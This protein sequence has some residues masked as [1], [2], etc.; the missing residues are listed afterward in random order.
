V[1]DVSQ[2]VTWIS[3]PLLPNTKSELAV[4]IAVGDT[5]LGV[6]DVQHDEEHAL[7]AE[8]VAL[9]QSVSSAVAIALQNARLYRQAQQR[10]DQESVVNQ[11]NQ[12]LLSAPTVERVLEIAAQGLGKYLGVR[13]ATVQL[14]RV[15]NSNGRHSGEKN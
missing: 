1:D 15:A 7:G 8:D 12:Q 9:L 2:I 3:N 10:A 4:P 6:L 5:V 11:I 14:S 13:R